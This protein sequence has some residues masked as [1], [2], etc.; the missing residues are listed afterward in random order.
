M[1][2]KRALRKISILVSLIL[3][4]S[5]MFTGVVSAGN[6]LNLYSRDVEAENGIVAAAKPE[7]SQVGIEI[8]KKGG[9][10]VDAAV[11]TGFALGV[12]EPNA[13]G[14]GGGGFMIIRMANTG[15]SVVIDFRE[16]APKYSTADMFK[17]DAE[18]KAVINQENI[19]GGKA[20]GVPGEVAGLLTA[21]ENYGTMNR[22]QIIQ[23]AIDLA[24]KG[25]PVTVNLSQIIKDEFDKI[26]RF[27]ATS[28]LYL[29]DGL[30]YEVGD[31]IVNNDLANSLKLIQKGGKDAFYNGELAKKIALEVQKQ[32]GILTV[33]DFKNYKVEIREPVEGTYRGYKIISTPPASSGGTHIIE[34]LNIMENYDL[35]TMGDNTTDTWHAWT[36]A[37]KLMFADRSKYMADTGFVKVPLKGLASKDYAKELFNK[38]DMTKPAEA[39]EAGD[40]WRYESGSTTS[41]SVMDKFG[42]MVTVTKSINYFFGSGVTIPGTGIIMNNHMDDFVLKPGSANSIEPGKRPLSSMSPTLVLDPQGRPFMTLGSPGA[43]RIITTVAQTISN[44]IDHGM[45]IQQAIMAPRIFSMQ[46]GTVKLEGR[47]SIKSYEDLKA[48]GHQVELRNDYDPYF[49]GVHAVLMDY[50]SKTL[51]GGAD[52]RRDGQA[53]GF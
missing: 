47:V 5:I 42:N 2:K 39:V 3:V 15:K 18:G 36:E 9:N 26:S 35:K 19:I 10:A 20:S 43:T 4:I 50:A 46:S 24:E 14:L 45:N 7:A 22:T 16:T 27:E 25:I 33:E 32:G 37:M 23:P 51:H 34:L 29:K 31:T 13:S 53:A 48:K 11:A 30:P 41:L 44:V 49:G 17:Y 1:E 6:P 38:I 12:L 52:P 21:L 40:A 28:D 8:L